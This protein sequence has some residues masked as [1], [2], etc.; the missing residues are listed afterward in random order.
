MKRKIKFF[1]LAAVIL[2]SCSYPP[3]RGIIEVPVSR[4]QYQPLLDQS[5]YAEY[6]GQKMIFDSIDIEAP[7]VTNF[8]YLSEDKKVGYTLFY[9]SD[10]IQQ[11]VVS[12]FWYV[13]Q[14]V[15]QDIGIDVREELV[16]KNVPKLD[17]KI[18]SLTDQDAKFILTLSR[19]GILLVQKEIIVSQK[20]PSTTDVPELKKRS[21]LFIDR[22]A[23]AILSDPDFK[24]EFF[25]DKGNIN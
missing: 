14:K 9:K 19:N 20:L 23:E 15:F 24:R 16:I 2:C 25:S 12:F 10:G 3:P 21:F 1:I 17:L 5:K 7:E 6:R 8:Y 4:D 18:M 13:L 11:P 22:I